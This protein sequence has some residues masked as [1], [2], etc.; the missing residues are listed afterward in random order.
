MAPYTYSDDF[1]LKNDD[2]KA[3]NPYYWN[4]YP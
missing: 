4:I 3:D 1:A 2:L